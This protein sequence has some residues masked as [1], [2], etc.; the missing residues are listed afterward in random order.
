M[1]V[2]TLH[3]LLGARSNRV[4]QFVLLQDA[5]DETD[6]IQVT[7]ARLP[8]VVIEDVMTRI[9][10]LPFVIKAEIA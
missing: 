6:T 10:A 4:R 5:Q 1:S 9:R 3:D 2:A 8:L 7:I